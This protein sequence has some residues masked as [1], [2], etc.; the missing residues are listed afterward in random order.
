M[1][2]V[3][4]TALDAVITMNARGDITGW[5]GQAESTFGWSAAE[6]IGRRLSDTII[7]F[8]L[9]AAHESG[10]ARFRATG[11]GPVLG[12]RIEITALR[13]N[14]EEFPVELAIASLPGPG[15]MAFSAFVRDISERKKAEAELVQA[16]EAAQRAN[17]A[18]SEFLATMSHEIRTPM[19]GILGFTE[20]LLDSPLD[21][22]QREHAETIRG[23]GGVLL[24]LINDI[25]DLSKIEAGR[26]EVERVPFD[27][28]EIANQVANLLAAKADERNLELLLDW[29]PTTPAIALGDPMRFRQVLLNLAGNAVKFTESGAI[30]IRVADQGAHAL[31]VEVKDTGIGIEPEK[32]GR[33]F[34]KFTQADSS[35]TRRFGGTGLGLA[36]SKQLVEMMGGEIGADS[37]PGEGSTFWFTLP[38][39]EGASTPAPA[40]TPASQPAR[41]RCPV[42]HAHPGATPA[43][44]PEAPPARWAGMR[45]LVAE[46]QSVNQKLAVN[47]LTRAGCVVDVAV[48]G[49]QACEL[50][51]RNTYD[52]V[53]MDCHMPE[54]DGFEATLAIRRREDEAAAAG[55]AVPHLPIIALTASVLQADRDRCRASGMDDF[56]SKPFKPQHL[57]AALERWAPPGA[58]ERPL[59]EA[60]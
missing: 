39:V 32:I 14:G 26:F 15:G 35:T 58:S 42:L 12:H 46:D 6:V 31:R 41:A 37:R 28:R 47:V 27:A 55:G 30:M 59:R 29:S 18:K 21:A 56:I 54:L 24:A 9:R 16:K 13:R 3:I 33:L 49:V 40:S 50:A 23:S 8:S 10:L 2:R 44:T 51:A 36:I 22:T 43:P 53:F 5:N 7:P 17:R 25:L 52:L 20:L 45:V 48:N 11:Q 34:R 38:L 4:E 57:L 60:A 19:N 1:L